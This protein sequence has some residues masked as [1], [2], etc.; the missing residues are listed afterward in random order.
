MVLA[1]D[2]TDRLNYIKAIE[3]QNEKLKEIAWLQSH[4]VRA[5]VARLMSLVG[6]I[7]NYENTE[8]EQNELL[9]YIL[10]SARELDD[11][12]RSISNKTN[13]I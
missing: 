5:P 2:I 9:D 3:N 12:I 6:L 13:K 1:T 7:K 11:V 8:E 10:M 4:V